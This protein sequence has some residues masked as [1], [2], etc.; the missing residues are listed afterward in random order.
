MRKR[1]KLEFGVVALGASWT[2]VILTRQVLLGWVLRAVFLRSLL[3]YFL[4]AILAEDCLAVTALLNVKW[5]L[6]TDLA[7]DHEAD[8]FDCAFSKL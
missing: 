6:F 8:V 5:D 4:K 1:A 3:L 2:L 7:V